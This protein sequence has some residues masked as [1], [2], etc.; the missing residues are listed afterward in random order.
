MDAVS[1]ESRNALI[2]R[3]VLAISPLSLAV[4][5]WGIL[6]GSYAIDIGLTPIE[7]QALSAILFA[8]AAQLVATGMFDANVGIWTMLVTTF[9]ITSRHFLYSMSMREKISPLSTRWRLVLGFLLT[10]ELFAVCGHQKQKDFNP[11]YAFGAGLS[12]YLVW[13]IASF[14]GIVAGKQIPNLNQWGLEFAVVATFIAI[15]I[16]TIKSLPILVSV[17]V[18]LIASVL[19]SYWKVE[20]SLIIASVLA[21]VAGYLTEING[22]KVQK[23]PS[24]PVSEGKG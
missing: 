22:I 24:T 13:N 7:A 3:G 20:G 5:P 1:R 10:D 6:A 18:A 4:I 17:I 8:G 11:W 12:F 14:V 23:K 2:W 16:P 19:L 15:V 9:F 21:M